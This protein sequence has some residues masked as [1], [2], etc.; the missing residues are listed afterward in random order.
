MV[1]KG[2]AAAKLMA[3]MNTPDVR[4]GNKRIPRNHSLVFWENATDEQKKELKW[5][6]VLY[7]GGVKKKFA[8]IE[9]TQEEKEMLA[10]NTKYHYMEIFKYLL[11]HYGNDYALQFWEECIEKDVRFE[12]N[13]YP[14]CRY[15]NGQ[16]DMFCD[17]YKEGVC[18]YDKV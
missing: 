8:H 10:D 12:L 6:S 5:Y 9:L 17:Y 11:D 7:G 16:C 13:A 15:A 1:I 3:D 18:I 14:R 2:Y 4:P